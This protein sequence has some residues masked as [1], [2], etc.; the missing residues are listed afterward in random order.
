MKLS[1]KELK[2]I[3]YDFNSKSNRLMQADFEDYVDVLSKFI[4]FIREEELIFD[5]ITSCGKIDFDLESEYQ[6]VAKSFG[7]MV[8]STGESDTE[9]IRNV[10]AILSYIADNK[11]K[12]D[13][14]ILDGYS[15][16]RK[17]QDK[18]KKFNERFVFV[19][20]RHIE[21]Y[22]TKI[23]FDMGIDENAGYSITVTNGQVNIANDNATIN[24]TNNNGIDITE[25]SRLINEVRKKGINL[26]DVYK[27]TLSGN[28]NFIEQELKTRKPRKNFLKTAI[29]GLKTIKGTVEFGTAT[30]ALIEFVRKFI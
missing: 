6:K 3:I 19:L 26:S 18:I 12:I 29:D 11:G 15:N 2:K 22:L 21:T 28:L 24:A 5:Y 7:R 10:Y 16:S 30:M 14:G 20:I 25:L 4:S 23:G 8:F 17:Y 27:E 9:E 1:K 13:Y